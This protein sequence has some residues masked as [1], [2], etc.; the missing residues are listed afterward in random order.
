MKGTQMNTPLK[1]FTDPSALTRVQR[2]LLTRFLEDN[3]AHLS[4]DAAALLTTSLNNLT[5]EEYC[6]A[7]ATQL[8]CANQFG[9]PLLEALH[10]VE[11]LALPENA[12]I[13]TDAL[14][15]LPRGYEINRDF[16]TLH[17]ALH[18]WMLAH[19]PAG[20]GWPGSSDHAAEMEA[21]SSEIEDRKAQNPPPPMDAAETICEL[22]SPISQPAPISQLPSSIS[23]TP[24]APLSTP[25]SQLSTPADDPAA[26][27]DADAVP[28]RR[29][30]PWMEP[31][32]DAV[33]LFDQV[34]DRALHYLF[35]PPGAATVFSLWPGHTHAVKAF[36]HSPRLH[37]T[38]TE[39]GCGKTT[40]LD[41]IACLCPDV[42]RTDNLRP[43]V[44]FRVTHKHE[45]TLILDEFDSYADQYPDLRGLINAGHNLHGC[46]TRCEGPN[47]RFFKAYSATA[48]AGIGELAPTLAQRSIIICLA[49]APAGALRARFDR[50][51][52]NFEI[53]LGRQIAR[54]VHDNYAAIAA[55]DPVMPPEVINRLADNWRP[56]FAI[57]QIIGGHWPQRLIEAFH[58]L[59][60]ANSAPHPSSSAQPSSI[61]DNLLAD[62]RQVFTDAAT[63][64]LF[65]TYVVR[66]LKAIPNRPWAQ[67]FNGAKPITE[68]RL[69]RYLASLGIYSKTLRV[70]AHVARGYLLADFHCS[71]LAPDYEI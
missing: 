52:T 8:T 53:T 21:G 42:L 57:A 55:C 30:K 66:A 15:H 29:L 40:A 44:L 58:Q 28:I 12:P 59:Q 9:A 47:V 26:D 16:S 11:F 32:P 46:A 27:T 34:H 50:R 35:L 71:P 1:L 67:A 39:P 49:R 22:P 48:L 64:R 60:A 7:W 33:A 38:S 36:T 25:H 13:L 23:A 6:S 24:A 18:L 56:L 20:V 63:T 14:S 17:Q 4:A 45:P 54:W 61:T 41:F 70:G 10:A 5:F 51:H 68:N 62:I 2:S 65:A 31:I 19:S 37:V 43:A 3:Q 69:S